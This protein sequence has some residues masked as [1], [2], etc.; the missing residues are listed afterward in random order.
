[1][2]A[3]APTRMDCARASPAIAESTSFDQG[4]QLA[5]GSHLVLG[6]HARGQLRQERGPKLAVAWAGRRLPL[7]PGRKRVW[8]GDVCSR[9]RRGSSF[10]GQPEEPKSHDVYSRLQ[11]TFQSSDSWLDSPRRYIEYP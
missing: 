6:R 4:L 10:I 1:M 2:R 9:H 8:L 3:S 5:A 7:R 11:E